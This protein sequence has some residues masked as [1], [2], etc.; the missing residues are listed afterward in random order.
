MNAKATLLYVEDDDSLRYVTQDNLSLAN[1]QV[2]ACADGQAALEAF[3][4]QP[5]DLCIIDVMLPKIDGLAVARKIRQL[6][7]QIPILFLSA[8][9]LK[10]DRIAGLKLG[11]DDYVTKP[12]SIEEL[13]LKVDIFLRRSKLSQPTVTPANNLATI[14]SY[15]FNEAQQQ[16]IY[17][18]ETRDL[19]HRESALL[20][21]LNA[22]V[23]QVVKREDILAAI[24]GED[25]YFAGRSLDVFISRLRKYLQKD[26]TI[27]I[28]NIHGVGFRLL[29][30]E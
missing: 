15:R 21:Y 29:V 3:R 7:N 16:L 28:E 9:C 24:W 23:N 5:I 10:E 27:L 8:K 11:A 14:G 12:F 17:Q 13:V 1:Y 4:D 25:D 20:G 22:H 18:D 19:T 2:V 6:N 30:A 26:S